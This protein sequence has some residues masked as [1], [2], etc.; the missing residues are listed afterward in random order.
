MA[1]RIVATLTFSGDTARVAVG[2][3]VSKSPTRVRV[4]MLLGLHEAS[5]LQYREDAGDR[6]AGLRVHRRPTR[7]VSD[8]GRW[9]RPQPVEDPQVG[10]TLHLTG[11]R[12]HDGLGTRG[13]DADTRPG[14]RDDFDAAGAERLDPDFLV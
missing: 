7:G 9:R 5:V 2:P 6:R 14:E 12:H 10:L 3:M 11:V 1:G 4:A 13:N 8:E